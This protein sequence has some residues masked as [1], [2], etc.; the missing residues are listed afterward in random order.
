MTD[1]TQVEIKNGSKSPRPGLPA[2]A[3]ACLLMVVMGYS[4]GTMGD[5][6]PPLTAM[7]AALAAAGGGALAHLLAA[8]IFAGEAARSALSF[9]SGVAVLFLGLASSA[10]WWF[11]LGGNFTPVSTAIFVVVLAVWAAGMLRGGMEKAQFPVAVLGAVLSGLLYF[12]VL[13]VLP[14]RVPLTGAARMIFTLLGAYLG[15]IGASL[16]RVSRFGLPGPGQLGND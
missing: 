12:I 14:A 5:A 7:A 8:R 6:V 2:F 13:F 10:V 1:S 15:F 4:I 9:V 3:A 11:L 16:C